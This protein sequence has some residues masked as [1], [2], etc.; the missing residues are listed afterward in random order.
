[1]TKCG[2]PSLYNQHCISIL[3]SGPVSNSYIVNSSIHNTY[4]HGIHLSNQISN[5]KISNNVLYN[6]SGHSINID[7]V[8]SHSNIISYNLIITPRPSW[9]MTQKDAIA[10]AIHLYN[11]LNI[12]QYNRLAGG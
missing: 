3:M 6:T 7:H 12:I 5:F 11:T 8:H 2:Q 1:M 9:R 10:S 4:A